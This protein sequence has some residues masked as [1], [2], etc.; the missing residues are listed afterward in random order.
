[1]SAG[2][3]VLRQSHVHR[4]HPVATAR[5][6]RRVDLVGLA[7]PDQV[8]NRGGAHE[9]LD[10]G[11]TSQAVVGGDQLLGDHALKGGR[12]LDPDLLLLVGRE[13]VDD[14][15]DRLRRVLRV[16]RR[17][18]EVTG[19]GRR[20]RR[21]DRL[22]VSHLADED[23]VRVLAEHVLEGLREAVRI[24]SDLPL[25]HHTAL[26]PVEELDRIFHG[27]DVTGSLPVHDVDHGGERGRLAG[28]RRARDHDEPTLEAREV[29]HDV[30]EPE[31]IHVLDLERDHPE[32]GAHGV[33]LLEHVHA[34]AGPPRAASTT[35]RARAPARTFTKLLR[36]DR[37]DH[38]LQRPR[39]ERPV[40]P[41]GFELAVDTHHRRG[42]RREVQVGPSLLQERTEQLGD[43]D[44]YI[45]F[46]LNH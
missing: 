29:H 17:E 5:L 15:V 32:D 12:Q 21:P 8:A 39:R 6:H 4:L 46:L 13:H 44:L 25:V 24:R 43:R 38:A 27:H 9:H 28:A 42:P 20:D 31:V 2:L 26:V 23:H 11:D 45:L 40:L 1:M 7:L 3:D 14:P 33:A 34:E 36:Q 22:E 35:C 41:R 16:Q 19:L 37:V 10:G 18:D 30:R